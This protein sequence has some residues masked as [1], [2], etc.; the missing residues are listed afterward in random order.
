MDV[1]RAALGEQKMSYIGW[2]YG[3]YLGAVYLQLFPDKADRFVLD[4]AV[5]PNVYGPALLSRNNAAMTAA[6]KNWAVWTARHSKKYHL[7]ATAGQVLTTV[8][9]IRKVTDHHPLKIGKYTIDS[10]QLPIL[11][12]ASDDQKD[13]YAEMAVNVRVL[14]D[15]ARGIKI[16]PTAN[17]EQELAAFFAPDVTGFASAQMAIV[18]ADRA[19]SGDSQTYYRDIQAHRRTEPLYG[20]FIRNITPCAFWPATPAEP[21]TQIGNNAAALI[22]NS[23]GDTQTPY[24]GAQVMHQALTGS[25]LVT[26]KNAYRHG[27]YLA[28]SGCADAAVDRYLLDGALPGSDITCTRDKKTA[29]SSSIAVSFTSDRAPLD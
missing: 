4:S 12:W 23:T 5:D 15:A 19:A 17:L 10:H 29:K 13:S 26:L 28:G 24:P 8:E 6:L 11:L 16:T 9:R 18:C 25:R 21:T 7:G 14:R 20:P 2:S 3:T 27:V 1:I 22:L